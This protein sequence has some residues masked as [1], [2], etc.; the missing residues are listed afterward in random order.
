MLPT[1]DP[2]TLRLYDMGPRDVSTAQCSCGRVARFAAGELQRKRRLPSDT[3]IYDLQFRLR[4]EF[5]R[6]RGQ[7]RILLWDGEPMMSRSPHDV[8]AHLVIVKG[9]VPER[10]R[11]LAVDRPA[12]FDE[13]PYAW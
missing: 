4:C 3:L 10:V 6:R 11:Y 5:C 8:G 7:V 1:A 9:D 13:R 2:R 12:I